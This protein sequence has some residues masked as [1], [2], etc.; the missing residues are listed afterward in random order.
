MLGDMNSG[1]GVGGGSQHASLI[2]APTYAHGITGTHSG[3]MTG[4]WPVHRAAD[5]VI[6]YFPFAGLFPTPHFLKFNVITR[7][8][9]G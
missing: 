4:Q 8:A 6:R 7:S 9:N 1:G 2:A 5:F 3:G